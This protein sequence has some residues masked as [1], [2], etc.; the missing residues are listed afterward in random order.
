MAG[1]RGRTCPSS[2][3]SPTAKNATQTVPIVMASAFDAVG[4]GFVAS[5]NRP[6]GNITGQSILTPEL[7]GKRLQFLI[8]AVPHLMHVAFLANPSHPSTPVLLKQTQAA[9]QAIGVSLI[10]V[11]A[12]TPDKLES[13]FAAIVAAGAGALLVQQA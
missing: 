2:I 4:S 1:S 11:E 8:E 13:A 9:A 10:V 7:T 12:T 3:V 5:L 6:G